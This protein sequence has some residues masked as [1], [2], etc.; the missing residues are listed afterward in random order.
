MCVDD[1]W[2][3]RWH[4]FSYLPQPSMSVLG[5]DQLWNRHLTYSWLSMTSRNSQNQNSGLM[6]VAQMD[7]NQRNRT[8]GLGMW[9]RWKGCTSTF[10][11][12]LLPPKVTAQNVSQNPG[13]VPGQTSIHT[14][15]HS[16]RNFQFYVLDPKEATSHWK[17]LDKVTTII[18]GTKDSMKAETLALHPHSFPRTLC[19]DKRGSRRDR[20]GKWGAL[21]AKPRNFIWFRGKEKP[22]EDSKQGNDSMG[23]CSRKEPDGHDEN[24]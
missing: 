24:G 15:V 22:Q 9:G 19:I 1:F 12:I 2:K 16:I 23:L 11:K 13:T 4:F 21:N 10:S 6:Y 7:E 14:G 8:Q 18:Q 3:D 17:E 5:L 20:L